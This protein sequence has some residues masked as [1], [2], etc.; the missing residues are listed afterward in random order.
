MMKSEFDHAGE[1]ETSLVLAIAPELVRMDRAVP[2]SKKLSK[3]KAA[4]SGITT[5]PGSFPKITGNG[6]WGN[7]RK[8][9]AAKGEK[10]IKEIVAGLVKTVSEL[11]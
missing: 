8:A 1:V 7:P 4:Y 6:V 2:N 10:W 5:A 11:A 9:T 3:S